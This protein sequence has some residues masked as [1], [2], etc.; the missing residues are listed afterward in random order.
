M[1]QPSSAARAAAGCCRFTLV[2]LLAVIAILGSVMALLLPAV[3]A[4][5]EAARRMQCQNHLKQLSLAF[6]IH[7]QRHGAFPSG[8]W[9]S[10]WVGVPGRGTGPR[11]PGGWAYQI[12]P[13]I[14]QQALFDLG[15]GLTG[16]ACKDAYLQR[17]QTPLAVHHCPS[18]RASRCYPYPWAWPVLPLGEGFLPA[19]TSVA[20]NDYAANL[21]DAPAS[22]CPDPQPMSTGR[23]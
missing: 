19:F 14:G 12:L 7:E 6:L 23:V 1:Q 21:G 9:G 16:E 17:L 10:T 15:L 11:Q 18:R 20:K 13:Y 4:A 5:R 3:Q 22:C 8:G 2:E